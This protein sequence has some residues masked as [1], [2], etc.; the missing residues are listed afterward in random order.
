MKA[1]IKT[2]TDYWDRAWG[3]AALPPAHD[4]QSLNISNSYIA[5]FYTL[6]RKYVEKPAGAKLIEV[7]CGRSNWLP[8]FAKYFSWTASGLDYSQRGC[9]QARAL[10]QRGG[11]TAD[12]RL[13]D[14]FSPPAD[15]LQYFDI[16]CSFGVVEHFD[17]TEIPL[18]AKAALLKDGG[19]MITMIPYLKG[20]PGYLQKVLNK[21]VYDIHKP[22][23]KEDLETFHK[24]CGLRIL[25]AG[26]VG[27]L[28][29]GVLNFTKKSSGF[30]YYPAKAVFYI[31]NQLVYHTRHVLK[32]PPN[33][34]TSPY[35]LVI[36]QKKEAP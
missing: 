12:I 33:S 6:F 22:S 35:V 29:F 31:F 16:V 18:R 11:V 5:D 1:G 30:L 25:Y 15:F 24:N 13:A 34:L 20:V 4:L 32:W 10:A 27:S 26:Y 3:G 23:H 28:H 8:F 14:M 2:T 9:E 21:E 17:E 7:G 19:I 36:A